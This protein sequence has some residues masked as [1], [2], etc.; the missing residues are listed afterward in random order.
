MIVPMR[1]MKTVCCRRVACLL[2]L[3]LLAGG[4]LAA[5]SNGGVRYDLSAQALAN[6]TDEVVL[7][8]GYVIGVL[9]AIASLMAIYNATV[10]YVKLQ[11]GEEGFSK[12]VMMLV[13][14][15][16]F[17]IGATIVMPSFFGYRLFNNK[18]ETSGAWT[19]VSIP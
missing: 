11:A 12:S 16:M 9:Y 4:A 7:T 8:M 13:G 19:H 2:M 17:L 3:L 5:V 14:A 18:F 6:M 10:I 1:L 15:I